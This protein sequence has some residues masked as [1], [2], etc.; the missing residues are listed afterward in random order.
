M[1]FGRWSAGEP[2]AQIGRDV[3]ELSDLADEVATRQPSTPEAVDA[4]RRAVEAAERLLERD[5][6]LSSQRRLARALWRQVSTFAVPAERDAVERTALRCWALCVGMLETARGD[7]VAFDDVVGDVGMWAGVLVPALGSAGR[8]A[9][10][11]QVYETS[12]KAA[13]RAMGARGRQ[14]RARLMM[15]PLAATADALAEHR[16]SVSWKAA[17]EEGLADAITSCREVL[18]VLRGHQR[19]GSFEVSEVARALQVLSRL[20]LIGGR[21]R[22]SAAALDEALALLGPVADTGPRYTAMLQ[23]LRAERDG[24]RGH[25]PDTVPARDATYAQDLAGAL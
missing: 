11:A 8:H 12:A 5:G 1:R 17:A 2:V 15:F 3:D 19:D 25:V 10:A 6:G 16:V 18:H 21:L 13:S 14:A 7:A 24:L 20:L 22:E 4:A 9:D 23:G